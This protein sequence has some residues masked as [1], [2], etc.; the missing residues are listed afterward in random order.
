MSEE[1]LTSTFTLLRDKFLRKASYLLHDEEDAYDALQE[2]FC[3]LWPK[4]TSISSQAEAEAITTTT[5]RN[6]CIDKLR[7]RQYTNTVPLLPDHDNSRLVDMEQN[8]DRKE[9]FH[10]VEQIINEQ[11]TPLQQTI[12]R[13][14]EYEGKSLKDIG[15][16]LD[17][18]PSAVSMQLSRARKTIRTCYQKMSEL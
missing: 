5:V 12:V 10:M 15:R 8:M 4:R 18:E 16:E 13:K 6:L 11:L 17:I 9:Q 1:L 7:S 14:K 3:R 2:A